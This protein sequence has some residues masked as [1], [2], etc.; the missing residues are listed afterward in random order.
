MSGPPGGKFVLPQELDVRPGHGFVMRGWDFTRADVE[1]AIRGHR[2]LNPSMELASNACPWSCDFCFTESPDN[3]AG[4]KRRLAGEM[5]LEERLTLV[6]DAAA[7]GAR[8]IN[9]VG[10]GEPTIDP[11]FWTIVE[12]IASRGMVPILYTEAAQR[13][14]D[15]AF[16]TRLHD[17]GAT[18]VVKVNS[19]ANAAY[20]N[21]V[22]R[23]SGGKVGARA[24]NY[25][26]FRNEAVD[27]LMEL[28][29]NRC[30]PTRLAF[31]TILCG[32][33]YSEIIDLHRWTRS[34]NI[35]T[36]GVAYLP[37]GRSSDKPED[38][39]T[40]QQLFEMYE[41]I[42]KI[43]ANEFG[44][45]HATRFPYGGGVPCTIRGTGLYTKIT[46]PVFDC[47]GELIPLGNLRHETLAQIWERARP[48]T[49]SFDGGCKP[50]DEA[51]RKRGEFEV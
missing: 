36:L 24:D 32:R 37:S 20:Q 15:R 31:D 35:F 13:L 11:D 41:Q 5:S 27:L 38:A 46:G 14:R 21:E 9:F 6:D 51:W 39:I 47:P 26:Q 45:K 10:A 34:R 42:A 23:G 33:N 40:R 50:R 1:Q 4:L 49:E 44:F 18:I 3:P 28:G 16:A 48:I 7:L 25:T 8:T 30:E 12:R 19:L 17:L 43:D 22:V 29:F 2:M